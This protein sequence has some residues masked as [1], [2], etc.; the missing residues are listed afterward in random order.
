MS[1]VGP[2]CL[3][4][5]M[6]TPSP[7]GLS[8]GTKDTP[9]CWLRGCGDLGCDY[10]QNRYSIR[11]RF[12]IDVVY[13]MLWSGKFFETLIGVRKEPL[14]E[15]LAK[16]GGIYVLEPMLTVLFVTN[17][18][19]VWENVMANLRS[20]V[21]RRILIQKVLSPSFAT[22]LSGHCNSHFVWHRYLLSFEYGDEWF[23][24]SAMPSC[25]RWSF[26]TV[27]R[28]C[29]RL[30]F[31]N[32]RNVIFWCLCPEEQLWNCAFLLSSFSGPG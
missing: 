26:L 9:S 10:E 3:K 14:G 15:L 28:Y 13:G 6:C 22:F 8:D 4:P 18:V 7:W 24:D 32:I 5:S 21:F 17:M 29:L 2:N 16:L 12:W 30:P 27:T 23:T 1:P 31:Q 19:H 25:R 11:N 20:Q